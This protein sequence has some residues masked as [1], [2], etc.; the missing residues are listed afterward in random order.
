MINLIVLK[1]VCL[2][3]LS[4]AIMSTVTVQEASALNAKALAGTYRAIEPQLNGIFSRSVADGYTTLLGSQ[5]LKS[6]P[7]R[8]RHHQMD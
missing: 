6:Y 8:G 3:T 4:G 2:M 7:E 1:L 5:R